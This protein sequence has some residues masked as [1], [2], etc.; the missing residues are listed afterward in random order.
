[1]VELGLRQNLNVYV[2]AFI[3]KCKDLLRHKHRMLLQKAKMHSLES[4]HITI[5]AVAYKRR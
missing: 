3:Q 5:T 1:M 2:A 4:F